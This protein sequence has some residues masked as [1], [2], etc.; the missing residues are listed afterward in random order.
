[1]ETVWVLENVIR[2][3][4]FYN[5]LRVL[6]LVAS[7]CL[8]R[9]YHP[10]HKTVFYGDDMSLDMVKDLGI[11]ILWHELRPLSYPERIDRKVFWS[12]PKTKIISQTEIPLLVIDHDFLIFKNI[13]GHLGSELMFTYNEIAN[14]WY[15]PQSDPV[16]KKLS[17]PINY[18]TS[19]AANVSLFYLPDPKF[20]NEYGLQVLK[21]HEEF[22]A[23]ND[24]MVTTNHMILSEQYMLRQWLYERKIPHKSLSKNLWDCAKVRYSDEEIKDGIW[25]KEE[26]LRNYKHFGVEEH[27]ILEEQPGYSLVDTIDYLYRC[28]NASKLI[29]VKELKTKINEGYSC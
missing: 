18:F 26:S 10:K 12:S 7:V 1:M 13:D 27:R 22:T 20:A 17:T 28:I 29:D 15:P 3:K 2:H 21:N 19:T 5:R 23:M 25:T 9:K 24:P 14:T 16:V 4:S 8:W 11:D 6:L